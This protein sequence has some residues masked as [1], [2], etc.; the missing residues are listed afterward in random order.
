MSSLQYKE[1]VVLQFISIN[2]ILCSI[3]RTNDYVTC[4]TTIKEYRG[5]LLDILPSHVHCITKEQLQKVPNSLFLVCAEFL[6]ALQVIFDFR[7]LALLAVAGSL[8]GSVLCFLNVI[9]LSLTLIL[10]YQLR[11]KPNELSPQ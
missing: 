6:L 3:K 11:Q 10:S 2:S 4:N 5:L 7:F 1:I 9:S 8:A